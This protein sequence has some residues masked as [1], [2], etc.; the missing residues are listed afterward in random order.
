MW[1]VLLR[2][3][4]EGSAPAPR[5]RP[6]PEA[7]RARTLR[8]EPALLCAACGHAI[9]SERE[10]IAVKGRH[11]HHCVNPAGLIFH[12]GCFRDARGCRVRGAA[13]TEFTWFPGFAWRY[14]VCAACGEHL[15][16]RFDAEA[17]GFFGLVLDRLRSGAEGE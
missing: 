2:D 12:I 6:A 9:T 7:K 15:G 13:T 14:A 8:P 11:D 1:L 10:R 17:D 16:W 5:T 4:S 3:S